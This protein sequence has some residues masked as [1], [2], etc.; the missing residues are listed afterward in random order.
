MSD[1]RKTQQ[2]M[3]DALDNEKEHAS[4]MAR[5]S[6]TYKAFRFYI[7]GVS[8]PESYAPGFP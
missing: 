3:F 5:A 2:H 8:E 1:R 6:E 4:D 7:L